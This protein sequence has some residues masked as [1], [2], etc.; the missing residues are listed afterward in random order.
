MRNNAQPFRNSEESLLSNSSAQAVVYEF[1]DSE[2][3]ESWVRKEMKTLPSRH[4]RRSPETIAKDKLKL[5]EL[6]KEFIG[7]YLPETHYVV[8]E[9][10]QGKPTVEIVQRK[11]FGKTLK[12]A[13]ADGSWEPEYNDARRD[14]MK[15]I[16]ALV[17]DGRAKGLPDLYRI[18]E[19][20]GNPENIMIDENKKVWVVDW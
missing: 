1:T 15:K 4:E 3:G 17:W 19:A 10:A 12:E 13:K 16:N 7:E 14:I 8:A 2:T 6:L 5:L 11:I 20:Y 9:N 18:Q